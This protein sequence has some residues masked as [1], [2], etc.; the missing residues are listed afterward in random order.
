MNTPGPWTFRGATGEG[1]VIAALTSNGA[2]INTRLFEIT[3]S[4]PNRPRNDEQADNARLIASAPELMEAL[5]ELI[6]RC[7]YPQNGLDLSATHDGVTNCYA[8]AKARAALARSPY[9]N[10]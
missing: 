4:L 9:Y 10:R 8:L 7:E 2:T 3:A 1:R 5:A 6:E